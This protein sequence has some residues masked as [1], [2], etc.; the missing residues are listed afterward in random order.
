ME[1]NATAGCRVSVDGTDFSVYEPSPFNTKWFSHKFNGAGLRYEIGVAIATGNIVWAHGP[2]PCGLYPDL[3]IFQLGMKGALGRGEIVVADKGY[4]DEKCVVEESLQ[5]SKEDIK[6]I[7]ARHETVNRRM[8]QFFVL[9]HKFRHPLSRHSSCF[10]A[11]ANLN[12]IMIANGEP[13]FS[14]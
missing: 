6:R 1:G 4:Q 11:V 3:K 8:K 13:L 10:H 2:F 7:R 14:M 12:Q 9:G 5:I